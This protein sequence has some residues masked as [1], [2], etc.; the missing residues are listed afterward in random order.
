MTGGSRK[1][2]PLLG[3]ETLSLYVIDERG[4]GSCS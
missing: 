4:N 1:R 3:F 2:N